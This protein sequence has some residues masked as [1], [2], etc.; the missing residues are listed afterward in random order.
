VTDL[1]TLA[2]AATRELLERSAPDAH[3]RYAD[4]RHVRAR[5]RTTALVAI[6]ASVALVIG[7]WQLNGSRTDPIEPAPRPGSV[8]NGVLLGLDVHVDNPAEAWRAI[9]GAQPAYLPEDPAAHA[10]YQFT[11][12]GTE[13]VYAD[14]QARIMELAIATGTQ[15]QLT[16]CPDDVCAAAVSPDARA[17]AWTDGDHVRLR[18][19]ANG[20]D[21]S[22]P[23]AG[24]GLV[25]APAWS[26]DG[27][28]LALVGADGLYVVTID[29]GNVR[30]VVPN[31]NPGTVLGP[32]SW[33]PT[34]GAVA[35]FIGEPRPFKGYE[36]TAFT[37]SAVDLT[38]GSVTS[39]LDAGQCFCVGLPAP[40]LTWSPD[41]TL[42]AVATTTSNTLEPGV[43]LV[44]PDGSDPE[45]AKIGLY[46]ALAWQPLTD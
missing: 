12:S 33:S 39:L 1:D 11:A 9:R 19:L 42:L 43:Y 27:T 2:R 14:G 20:A 5:R 34:N 6:A 31:R 29:S 17:I 16:R 25:G 37:A 26:P 32:V 18:S 24:D 10:Q 28:A 36:E 23:A 4:L 46:A 41:G 45:R 35:F 30:L 7:G 21:T 44:D 15:R 40:T 38:T 8:R 3:T 22:I 13:V